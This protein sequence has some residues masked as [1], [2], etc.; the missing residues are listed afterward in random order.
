M[1][2]S[3]RRRRLLPACAA[4]ALLSAGHARADEPPPGAVSAQADELRALSQPIGLG[5]RIFGSLE[6]G[7]G[8]RFNNPYRL[9]TEL[10]QDARSVSLTAAYADVGVGATFGGYNG[11]QHGAAV[12]AS[13]AMMGVPQA[14]I[15]PTYLLAYR[16]P[17]PFL[18]YGRLG[19]SIILTP[20][21]A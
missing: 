4:L 17:H 18:V 2:S 21:P 15:T 7:R 20:D 13:F 19:P 10:G 1:L 3:R 6:F 14:V 5:K 11:L 8:F 16:G 9:A 12:H